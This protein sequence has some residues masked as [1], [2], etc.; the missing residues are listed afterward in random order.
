MEPEEIGVPHGFL[1]QFSRLV[2]CD[3]TISHPQI[4]YANGLTWWAGQT[5]KHENGH[6]FDPNYR[7]DYESFKG[8]PCPEKKKLI[9][10]ICSKNF[11][12]PGH[13]KRLFFLERLQQH[14][15]SRQIDFFGGGF[16]PIDDKWD[17]IAPYKYHIVLENSVIPDYW[18]EKLADAFLGFSLPVYYGCPNITEYFSPEA[19]RVIDIDDFERSISTLGE[20]IERDLF[21]RHLEAITRARADVLDRYNIFQMMSEICREPARRFAKC[22]LTP[23]GNFFRSWPKRVARKIIYRL[24]GIQGA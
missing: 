4:T 15:L 22:R 11:F 16:R 2:L 10:V 12:L 3:R 19:L 7:Y 5:V 6:H 8:I 14:S 1:V 21:D 17:A 24:R 23:H 20:L 18:T 9:S 13:K